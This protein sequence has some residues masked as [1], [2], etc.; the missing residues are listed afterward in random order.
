VVIIPTKLVV[1]DDSQVHAV[2]TARYALRGDAPVPALSGANGHGANSH[3]A[4]GHGA[5]GH[6]NGHGNGLAH[7]LPEP[8]TGPA[9]PSQ[10]AVSADSGWWTRPTLATDRAAGSVQPSHV[11]SSAT[12][13]VPDP[14]PNGPDDGGLPVRVRQAS[15]APQLQGEATGAATTGSFEAA[16]ASAEAIRSTLSA[17]QRGWERGRSAAQTPGGT[18]PLPARDEEV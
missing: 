14:V 9:G 1:T 6:G 8:A 7:S 10:P 15:L 2:E 3:G 4:N 18:Q 13:L 17:M 12:E 16:P 5:N 11:T